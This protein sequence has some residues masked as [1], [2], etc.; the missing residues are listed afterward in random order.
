[1]KGPQVRLSA[2]ADTA[3]SVTQFLQLQQQ[4]L[5]ERRYLRNLTERSTGWYV[6]VFRRYSNLGD[7]ASTLPTKGRLHQ[8]VFT[9]RECGVQPVTINSYRT[10]L[11]ALCRWM[12]EEG[13]LSERLTLPHLKA[14][15]RV[16]E[17]LTDPQV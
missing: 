4:F 8:F 13:H 5:T 12:H 6:G 2:T 3:P 9:L 14:P 11:N 17:T 15:T 16:I 7:N 1:M 10:A